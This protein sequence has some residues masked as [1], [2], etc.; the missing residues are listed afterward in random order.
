MIQHT[1]HCAVFFLIISDFESA[2]DSWIVNK[3]VKVE[4]TESECRT[5]IS[6][7][8][9]NSNTVSYIA[10]VTLTAPKMTCNCTLVRPII[11]F[12]PHYKT[13]L[14]PWQSQTKLCWKQGCLQM[15]LLKDW[16]AL[17]LIH[18][19]DKLRD[20]VSTVFLLKTYVI[21]DRR[22]NDQAMCGKKLLLQ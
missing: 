22:W 10:W 13:A 4:G 2:Q 19:H 12:T 16:K 1:Q 15:T 8:V 3:F 18:L 7:T 5:W 21:S 17:H 20:I 9:L 14:C 11:S 6:R